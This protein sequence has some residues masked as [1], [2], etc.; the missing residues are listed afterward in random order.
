[1]SEQG[2]LFA[3]TRDEFPEEFVHSDD[4]Q[5]GSISAPAR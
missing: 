1:M 2:E 5:P 3:Y 4:G